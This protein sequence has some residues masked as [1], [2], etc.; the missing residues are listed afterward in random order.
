MWP[1]NDTQ[2][3]YSDTFHNNRYPD[4]KATDSIECTAALSGQISSKN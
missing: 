3:V 1:G 2:I 4:L